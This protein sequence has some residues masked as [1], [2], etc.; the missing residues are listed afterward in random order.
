MST[1]EGSFF[2]R[3]SR[4]KT[5]VRSGKDTPAEPAGPAQARPV[6][7]AGVTATATAP[8][9]PNLPARATAPATSPATPASSDEASAPA[10]QPLTLNDVRQLTPD[11]D[12]TPFVARD[13]A[14]EVRNAA[15]KKL[16]ADPKFNVMDGLDIYIDDYSKPDPLPLKLARSLVSARSLGLFDEPAQA[17][18]PKPA[19]PA[20]HT[21]ADEVPVPE[22]HHPATS[23]SADV[24]AHEPTST[25]AQSPQE[26]HSP[27][28]V[29]MTKRKTTTP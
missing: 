27:Q 3:W 12:F 17:E 26:G 16:F 1:D 10:P 6:A 2:S 19:T 25:D 23:E 18:Q 21:A 4:R 22:A 29:P 14:P 24:G 13:V 9:T 15:F 11:A 28:A 8:T 7:P 5:E 20:P